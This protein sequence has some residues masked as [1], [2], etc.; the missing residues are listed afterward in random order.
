MRFFHK[1]VLITGA[2]AGIGRHTA[3]QFAREG[4]NVA[5]FARR[6]DKLEE[7]RAEIEAIGGKALCL[8]GD[9]TSTEDIA[10]AFSAAYAEFGTLD[11]LVNNAGVD[12]G[13]YAAV[14]CTDENWFKNIQVN[15]KAVFLCMREGL[16]YMVP[17]QKGAI[18]NLSSIGGVYAVAGAAYSAAK[19]AVIGLT[20]NAAIQY[21][22]TDIRCN[23]VCPGPV[24]T[25]MLKP[26]S[27]D[28]TDMEML[29]ITGKHID[30]TV[31]F[32]EPEDISNAIMFFADDCSKRITGQ[33]L[34][35]DGGRCL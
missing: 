24:P 10:Q 14:R 33:I 13:S 29:Q 5:L 21:A 15:E 28:T 30:K 19:R 3:L 23:A 4:A 31:P 20:K 35:V 11:I 27:P 26:A 8:P 18:I 6:A 1:T 32:L 25:D 2:S 17:T 34:V 16:K 7:V 12:D 22:G 9:V